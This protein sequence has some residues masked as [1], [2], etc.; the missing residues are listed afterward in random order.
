MT[1]IPP[2][3]G[4]WLAEVGI[5]QGNLTTLERNEVRKNSACMGQIAPSNLVGGSLGVVG[6]R[7]AVGLFD[8]QTC[9]D[10]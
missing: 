7:S 6:I 10:G 9:L 5:G 3:Q 2:L 8:G 4:Q 1:R